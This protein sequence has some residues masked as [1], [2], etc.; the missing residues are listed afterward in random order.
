MQINREELMELLPHRAP[1]RFVDEIVEV[2]PLRS[3]VAKLYLDPEWDIFKGH[4]P[5]EPVFPGVLAV[6]AMAQTVD[7]MIMTLDKYRELTPLFAEI[8]KARFYK[9]ILPGQTVYLT[10]KVV[11]SNEI[12]DMIVAKAKLLLFGESHEEPQVAAK[13]IITIAESF[14]FLYKVIFFLV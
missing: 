14:K 2:E 12:K 3:I 8:Q 11:E 1:M 10:A 7:C 9:R 5:G 4:F 13:A 6:E